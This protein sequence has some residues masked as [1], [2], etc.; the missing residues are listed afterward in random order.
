MIGHDSTADPEQQDDDGQSHRGFGDGDAD[1]ED[2]KDHPDL[3]AAES[4]ERDQIDVDRVEHQLDAEQDAD[5]VASRHDTEQADAKHDGGEYEVRL[6][7]HIK[8]A[9]QNAKCR[10]QKHACLILWPREVHG[11]KHRG[12]HQH[13]KQLERQHKSSKNALANRASEIRR[14]WLSRRGQRLS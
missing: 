11:A 5:R 2:G 6:Q 10:M 3:A 8:P 9:M 14:E 4:G 12:K 13:A 7:A 1:R